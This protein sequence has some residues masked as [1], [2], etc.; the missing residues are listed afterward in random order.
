VS[1]QSTSSQ[2]FN[3]R[4]ARVYEPPDR[5]DGARV[6]VDR[7]W[8][9]GVSK[10]SAALHGW[11]RDVAPSTELRRWY[12]HDPDRFD[13]FSDR[14]RTELESADANAA[15]VAVQDLCRKGTVTLLTATKAIETS[16]VAVLTQ[17]LTEAL[18]SG[19]I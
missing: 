8:P 7:L 16:H 19:E 1:E 15:L 5:S 18:G 13:E 12:A 10:E 3:I 4:M 14:Y 9:R 6:L 2:H 11:Y 17:V